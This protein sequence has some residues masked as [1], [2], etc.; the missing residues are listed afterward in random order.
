[1]AAACIGVAIAVAC[2]APA[3][4]DISFSPPDEFGQSVA[5]SADG[6]TTVISSPEESSERGAAR[7]FTRSG[8]A[9]TQQGPPL[10]PSRRLG[11]Q[12]FGVDVTLSADGNTALIRALLGDGIWAFTRSG[13][14]W[15]RQ[16]PPL[17][18]S[19]GSSSFGYRVALSGDG[20]TAL[21]SGLVS[22]TAD[23]W[24]FTRSG[25]AWTQQ[26][27][28]LTASDATGAQ[29]LDLGLALSADGN[30]ALFG[31]LGPDSPGDVWVFT[32]S[33]GAWTQQGP[34]LTPSDAGTSQGFGVR[35]ALS[36][37]GN[38]ALIGGAPDD[39]GAKVAWVFTRSGGA[40][41]QQGPKLTRGSDADNGSN[42]NVGMAL[43]GDG[44]TAVIGGA[45]GAAST[46]T[47]WVFTRFG[48][49][50]T[51]QGPPLAPAGSANRGLFGLS[52]ALSADGNTT[53][54]GNPA[55]SAGGGA[56]WVFTRSG[57]GVW[58]QQG[59]KLFAPTSLVVARTADVEPLN[60]T[61]LVKQPGKKGFIRLQQGTRIRMGSE[62]D[63]TRGAVGLTTAAGGGKAQSG[64]F[65]GGLFKLGQEKGKHPFTELKLAAKFR[66]VSGHKTV[67]VAA[68]RPP[69]RHLF[70]NAHGRFRTRGRNS[71]ATI[72]GT[73]WL[74]KDTCK[75]T[76]TV[77]Q[78]GTVV[79]QDLVKHRTVT[80][81][82]GQR[83]VARRGNR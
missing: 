48:G 15:T 36:L 47:A 64:V 10:I 67:T 21:L 78:R 39:N 72:R 28:P 7:V 27:A 29:S 79:V 31:G 9:W 70:G 51:Q 4:A 43:S 6:D 62:V 68:K 83:Y 17:T 59:P 5:L 38:T 57:G 45:D 18:P 19:G 71:V 33:G 75:S 32:R 41:S 8:G 55:D 34:P 11:P 26:G 22:D 54:I 3:V 25:G 14:A 58:A 63:T 66:C 60:G 40:W 80:L 52:A 77:S 35:G 81:K 12:L 76:L 49:A 23:V 24:V 44:N 69:S 53:V 16:G 56:A 2:S 37:D 42:T 65:S 73:K 82:S 46:G 13:G 20:S 30:T 74:V 1:M 61:V 50:W